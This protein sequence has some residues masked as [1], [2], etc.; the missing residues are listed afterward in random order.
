MDKELFKELEEASKPLQDFL[1]KH[2]DQMTKIEVEIGHINVL[3]GVMGMPTEIDDS[4]KQIDRYM[5]DKE[6]CDNCKYNFIDF[7]LGCYDRWYE[8][9][10][11]YTRKIGDNSEMINCW[12]QG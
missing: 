9:N 12:E 4:V 2:F 5:N 6:N 3:N 8:M 11:I 7:N 1:M 10:R